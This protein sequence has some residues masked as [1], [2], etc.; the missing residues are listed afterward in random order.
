M[1]DTEKD[2]RARLYF[3]LLEQGHPDLYE[4]WEVFRSLSL[5]D[6]D[7][8]YNLFGIYFDTTLG[9][10]FSQTMV[11]T[12]ISDLEQHQFLIQSE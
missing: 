10:S 12:I 8:I 11:D 6:F 2:Q 9:E 7:Q 4:L 3:A 5:Q 1:E